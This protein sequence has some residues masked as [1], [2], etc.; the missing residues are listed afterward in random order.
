MNA[1]K[2]ALGQLDEPVEM[3][4]LPTK[5]LNLPAIVRTSYQLFTAHL[6]QRRQDIIVAVVDEK[7]DALLLEKHA[8]L[9][10]HAANKPI[11]FVFERLGTRERERLIKRRI[12]FLVPGRFIYAPVLGISGD[13]PKTSGKLETILKKEQLSSWAET[14]VIK[15]LLDGGLE[16]K[17]G[18]EISRMFD[19]GPIL[20]SQAL[21]ELES[22]ELCRCDRAGK[23]KQVHFENKQE[24]WNKVNKR[25][26]NPVIGTVGLGPLPLE[27]V[28][29]G[30][31]ALAHYS[32]L[33]ESPEETFAASKREFTR[34]QREKTITP[35]MLGNE[36]NIVQLWR[37]DPR[38]LAQK[39]FI[40]QVSLYL[41]LRDSSDQRVQI[42]ADRMLADLGIKVSHAA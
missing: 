28:R 30:E 24:L 16:G 35:E 9:L 7:F 26:L 22:N 12:Q 37:R 36:Q 2:E 32:M 34:L 15:Q 20:I 4:P 42:E 25:L 10:R 1:I 5:G 27:L 3:Q 13:T 21:R 33:A 19:V 29:A 23:A 38:L 40:D 8:E 14:L 18:L 31:T 41:S 17:H 39:G 11:I 6:T